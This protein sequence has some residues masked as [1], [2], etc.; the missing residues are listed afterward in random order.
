MVKEGS[1]KGNDGLRLKLIKSFYFNFFFF[2]FSMIEVLVLVGR[3]P[4]R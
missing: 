4:L 2:K 1:G 3:D